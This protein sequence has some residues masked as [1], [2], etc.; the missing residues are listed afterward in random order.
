MF[1]GAIRKNLLYEPIKILHFK[2][3]VAAILD[4]LN[5]VIQYV[6]ACPMQAFVPEL[7]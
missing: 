2:M 5:W 6:L 7:I 3:A 4:Q 1:L